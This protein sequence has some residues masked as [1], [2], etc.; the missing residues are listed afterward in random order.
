V[1]EA[2]KKKRFWRK[3][4]APIA[5]SRVC[6]KCNVAG[7]KKL[8]PGQVCA[9]CE[10]QQAW[11][12]IGESGIK[13]D[14]KAIQD[15]VTR[16]EGEA[17]GEPLWQKA[18]GFAPVLLSLSVAA[19]AG[20]MIYL[21]LRPREIG[22]LTGLFDDLNSSVR[23]AFFIGIGA[24]I[25]GVVALVRSRKQRSYRKA[26]VLIAHLLAIVAGLGGVVIGG[27]HWYAMPSSFGGKYSTMPPK[28]QLGFA[29][30][31]TVDRIVAATVV[32]LAPGS[33]G[34]ARELAMGTGA[35]IHG[36]A[37]HAWIVTC[38]HVA[39]PYAAVGS[40]RH[41]KDAQPVWVQLS[42]GRQ[43]KGRVSWAAPPPLDIA[44]IELDIPNPPAPIPIAPN[45]DALNPGSTVQF[46]P[47]PYRDGWLLHT[48]KLLAKEAH[49][50]P[51]GTYQLLLTDLPVTHGDSGSGLFD[52]RGQLVGLNTWTKV[53]GGAAHG[54]SLPS[55]A[56]RALADAVEHDELRRLDDMLPPASKE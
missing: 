14:T 38:S 36:D 20:W 4:E 48:G 6:P 22:P 54:I 27:F 8:A 33:N 46:V 16:R 45:A 25:V 12:A 44:V 15:A 43:G 7:P 18:I 17:A 13:I 35:I 51:A 47:N 39:M 9:T 1:S 21:L 10:A 37:K 53:E 24:F 56:M 52:E 23:R 41:A 55:E 3:S 2:P 50:T 26:H 29:S 30:T 5:T 11:N 40:W 28:E 32:V 42:D 49:N 31:S 19:F 34:D